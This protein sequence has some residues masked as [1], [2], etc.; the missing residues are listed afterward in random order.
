VYRS[1]LKKALLISL[2]LLPALALADAQADGAGPVGQPPGVSS[3]TPATTAQ[4]PAWLRV[5]ALPFIPIPEI[6]TAPH[7]GINVGLFPIVLSS[8]NDGQINQIL[9]PDILHSQYFGWGFRWRTFRNPSDDE[10]WSLVAGAKQSVER[11][12]DFEYDIGLRR[13]TNWS[14]VLHAMFDRSGTGRFYGFGNNTRGSDRTTFIYGQY[15]LEGTAA[16]N[17]SHELQLAYKFRLAT[18]EIE[19]TALN[20]LPS[21]EARYPNLRGVGDS[22]EAQQRLTLTDDTR[23]SVVLPRTGRR[24]SAFAGFSSRAFGGSADYSFL[25]V[26][27]SA[28][29]PVTRDLTIVGHVAARY[30]PSYTNAPFWAYS[31]IGGDRDIIGEGQPLRGYG[32]GRFWGRNSFSA[33]IEAREWVRAFHFFKSDLKLEVAPFIDTGKV[34]STMAESPFTHLHAVVGMGFRVVVSP[35]VVGYVDVGMGREKLAFFSGID[36]PF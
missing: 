35:F 14:W 30:M 19:S 18:A 4:L 20:S 3:D 8:N 17:F 7:E 2:F 27:A 5:D 11:E 34:F 32:A 6:S 31:Q 22:S 33:S 29:R 15:R 1:G 23:D 25:G 24:L 13:D 9:A 16:R 10:K 21:I 36:Y 26:D 12:F 28:F